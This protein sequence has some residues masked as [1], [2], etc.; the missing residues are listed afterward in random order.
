MFGLPGWAMIG[1]GIV[2]AVILVLVVRSYS[3]FQK[4]PGD[5]YQKD[6]GREAQYVTSEKPPAQEPPPARRRHGVKPRPTPNPEDPVEQLIFKTLIESFKLE[7]GIDLSRD[8][9]PLTLQ[10]LQE[11]AAQAKQDLA[12]KE[13]VSVELPFIA[14]DASG[15]KTLSVKLERSRVGL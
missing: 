4:S 15:P 8:P 13:K 14:V 10:R 7:T 2:V 5:Q 3:T 11:A 9:A 6:L 12:E 1:I